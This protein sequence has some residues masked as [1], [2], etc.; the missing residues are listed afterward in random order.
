M[1]H[2][3]RKDTY[4]RGQVRSSAIR[5]YI[6]FVEGR[7]TEKSY[8]DLLKKS[9]CKI[10]PVTRKGRGISQCIDFVNDSE[11]TW[12]C[13]PQEEREKYSKRWLVFDDDGRPDFAA[14]IKLARQKGFGV[15]FSSMCIEYWFLLHFENHNGDAIPMIGDSHSKAQ[16]QKINKHIT[17]YNKKTGRNIKLYNSGSKTVEEDFFELMLAYDPITHKRRIVKAFE[18]AK[19]MH[20]AKKARGTEFRESVTTIY[21][22]LSALGVIE[23]TKAGYDLYVK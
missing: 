9:N 13:M 16:I 1:D 5:D 7:N 21:E 6:I 22:L 19:Q 17:V 18:L 15:A 3:K 10:M 20:E 8:L 12:K 4:K 2:K 23:K 11:N 14:G